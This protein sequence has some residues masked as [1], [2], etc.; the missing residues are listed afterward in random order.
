MTFEKKAL[1]NWP[2]NPNF[3]YNVQLFKHLTFGLFEAKK[4]IG[5][6]FII[7]LTKLLDKYGLRKKIITYVKDGGF[8]FN[9]MT[10]TL[11]S[12]ASCESFSL[13]KSLQGTCFKHAFSKA[14]QYDS[15]RKGL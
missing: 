15:R 13:E 9:V 6:A 12:I 4:T 2:Y 3:Q 11:K 5:Q 8:N 1:S 14:C 10:I 7:T